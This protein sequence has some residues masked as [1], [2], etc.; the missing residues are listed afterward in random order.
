MS[1]ITHRSLNPDTV[2]PKQEIYTTGNESYGLYPFKMLHFLNL[3]S[4]FRF[5]SLLY[6]GNV[7]IDIIVIIIMR[8]GLPFLSSPW[9]T[10][11]TKDHANIWILIMQNQ[12][13]L[14][15]MNTRNFI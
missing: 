9:T 15:E 14:R 11:R 6:K 3:K 10:T 12:D 8:L 13:G 7:V 4:Y 2:E 5:I 1:C